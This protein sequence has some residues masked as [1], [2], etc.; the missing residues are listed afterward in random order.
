VQVLVKYYGLPI[1]DL[2]PEPLRVKLPPN[3]TVKQLFQA[4]IPDPT[5]QEQK[6]IAATTVMIRGSRVE[7]DEL[8]HDGDEVLVISPLAGG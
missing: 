3:A 6:F 2:G 4:I 1:A 7:K 5:D 8:L